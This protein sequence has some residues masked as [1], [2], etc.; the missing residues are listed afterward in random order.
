M[1]HRLFQWTWN[2]GIVR[3][4]GKYHMSYIM[5]VESQFWIDVRVLILNNNK[6]GI[7]H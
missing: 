5:Y 2:H 7:F 3:W 1:I 6:L 4:Y